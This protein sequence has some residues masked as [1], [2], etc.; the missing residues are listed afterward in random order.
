MAR[1][2]P[3]PGFYCEKNKRQNKSLAKTIKNKQTKFPN[4]SSSKKD[5][6]IFLVKIFNKMKYLMKGKRFLK[7]LFIKK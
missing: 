7:T 5:R 4:Y 1:I 6:K 3:Q 2:R